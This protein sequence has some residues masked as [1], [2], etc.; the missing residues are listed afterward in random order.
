MIHTLT[1]GNLVTLTLPMHAA[2][3]CK[4]YMNLFKQFSKYSELLNVMPKFGIS[5]TNALELV[6]TSLCLVQWFLR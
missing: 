2:V 1:F 3:E 4:K 5:V 6:Q